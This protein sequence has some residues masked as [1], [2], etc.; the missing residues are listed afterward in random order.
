MTTTATIETACRFRVNRAEFLRQYETVFLRP[1][2][3]GFDAIPV[4]N[5]DLAAIHWQPDHLTWMLNKNDI[6]G[7]ASQAARVV[8]ETPK[9]LATRAG[10]LETRLSF[11]EAVTTVHYAGGQVLKGAWRGDYAETPEPGPADHG[12]VDVAAFVPEGRNALLIDYRETAAAAHPLTIVLE[13][14]LQSDWG[15]KAHAGARD[16]ALVLEF[17]PAVEVGCATFA[18]ALVAEG[19]AGAQPAADGA[20]RLVLTVPAA[21]SFAGRLAVAVVTSFEAQDPAGAAVALAKATLAADVRQLRRRQRDYWLND[22]WGRFF[23]DSGHPYAT[24]LYMM[25]LYELGITSRGRTPVKFN[26]ALNL[27]SEKARAWGEGYTFHNQHS[28]HLPVYAAN[29]PRL[30]DNF[31]DWII[32]V[33]P[34]AVKSARKYFGIEGAHYAEYMSQAYRTPDP[35]SPGP[36]DARKWYHL[37]YILSTGTRLCSLLWDRYQFTLDKDFL[38]RAYPVLRDVAEFYVNYGKRGPDGHYH[39]QPSQ[40]WEESPVG[41]DG[42][43]DCAAW[44]AVFAMTI[45][46]ATILGSD[47]D[48]I[49]VWQERLKHAPEYP[50]RDG[51]FSVVVRN[52]GTPEPPNHFQWQLPNLSGVF[53][54]GVI[55]MDG[56]AALRRTAAA[57]FARYRHN[58][59]AGH[60]YLPVVAARLGDAEAWR[61]AL[62]TFVQFFQNFD[63]GLFNYYSSMGNKDEEYA[64]NTPTLHP[65][66]ESSGIFATAVNEML[67]QSHGNV[68]R[69]FP[70][71]PKHWPCRFLLLARGAFLVASEHRAGGEIPYVLVQPVGGQT[72]TCQLAVPWKSGAHVRVNGKIVAHKTLRGKIAFEARPDTVYAVLPKG[73]RLADVPIVEIGYAAAYSPSRLG[74]VWYGQKEGA[75]NHTVTFPLW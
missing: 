11:A 3:H 31:H 42:H 50:V 57:T 41:R 30:A 67:L 37:A 69:V 62:F 24:A 21:T 71:A 40:S 19:F 75:N 66:L 70:A 22:F 45:E 56:P 4:G 63:Q 15:K 65:Y 17:E 39:L 20:W 9:P 7:A 5:G 43:G 28:T 16:G 38:G 61:A 25:A 48:R 35:E 53:P 52:D 46:A 47:A 58:A 44:R 29:H 68:I 2:R 26:G 51:V 27:W 73:R 32:G 13:R 60:E 12:T 59:D 36:E 33:R 10:R 54:Y 55:G 64:A 6:T 14:W 72:R 1:I 74:A 23:I 18:V 34:E 8:I 49:P